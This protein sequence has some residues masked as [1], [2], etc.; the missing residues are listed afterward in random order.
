[1]D[2]LSQLRKMSIIVEDADDMESVRKLGPRDVSASSS[3]LL[4]AAQSPKY[5]K[6]LTDAVDYCYVDNCSDHG[7]MQP[8]LDKLTVNIGTQILGRIAGRVSVEVNPALSFDS[9]AIVVAARRLIALFESEKTSR[10]RILIRI[11]A[12]WEGIRAARQ[13]EE[14]GIHCSL[15]LLFNFAQAVACAEAGVTLVSPAVGPML[16]WHTQQGLKTSPGEDPGVASLRTM[17]HYYKKFGY[18][19]E[20]MGSGFRSIDQIVRLAGVDLLAVPRKFVT[21]L[22]DTEGLVERQLDP[23]ASADFVPDKLSLNEKTFRWMMN[24]DPIGTEKLAEGIRG[25]HA[26]RKNLLSYIHRHTCPNADN[27]LS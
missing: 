12:T 5:K 23:A 1:M 6:Q 24:Q 3:F 14:T 11:P 2:L 17:Y 4:A 19:T 7:E 25:L 27:S 26:D 15:I 18:R 20:V 22:R 13:L 21:E 16:D 9:D 8:C 10:L